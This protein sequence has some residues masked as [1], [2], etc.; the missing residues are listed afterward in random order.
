MA[1]KLSEYRQKRDARRTP[2]PFPDNEDGP[3]GA[4]D[5][6]VVQEHHARQLH[7][8]VRL[9]REG[10]LVSWAVP[11]G[12]PTDPEATHLAVHTE[13]HPLAYAAFEGE[14]P[15][16]EYGA[17]RMTIWA[18]GRYETLHWNDHKVEFVLHGERASGRYELV[19][20]HDDD[21]PRK[22]LIRRKDPAPPG[23]ERLPSFLAPMLAE[24]G[25]MPSA[26][27]KGRWAY[28]FHWSGLRASA[29]IRG[30]RVAFLDES[31]ASLNDS[32]PELRGLGEGFG[33]T[34][35]YLDGEIIVL[36]NGKPSQDALTRRRRVTTTSAAKRLV[37]RLPAVYV[38]YDVLHLD[39][40]ARW[41]LPYLDRRALLADLGLADR[42]WQAPEHYLDDGDAVLE[43][44]KAHGLAGIVAKRTTGRYRSGERSR[45]WRLI[46][47]A[48]E[49]V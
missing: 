28:E 47:A 8:D 41:D 1:G 4:G 12:L 42:H 21:E 18:C 44:S 29:R 39:G 32:F 40:K 2:E 9:E 31:G 45:D 23:W 6:F 17:G 22:W 15:A 34:E 26:A 20:Q 27:P 35:A 36:D 10:V 11:M 16:G 3:T 14:I 30:G 33:S 24:D 13:D 7:W 25:E 37:Q 48:A 38:A 43:A 46:P 49:E 19:N 5:A